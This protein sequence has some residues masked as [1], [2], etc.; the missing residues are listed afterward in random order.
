MRIGMLRTAFSLGL[1]MFAFAPDVYACF[2]CNVQS[3][4]TTVNGHTYYYQTGYCG[5]PPNNSWGYEDCHVQTEYLPAA[6]V[7]VLVACDTYGFSC[8]YTE[9]SGG[10]GGGGGGGTGGGGSGNPRN[11]DG[12]CPPEYSSC[13]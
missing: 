10:G 1:V 12:S 7:D 9:V 5:N 2:V 4:S 8:Y 6:E 13:D 11:P 3:A